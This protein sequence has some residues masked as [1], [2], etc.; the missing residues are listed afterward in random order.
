MN[1]VPRSVCVVQE[2]EYTPTNVG[3]DDIP[4]YDEDWSGVAVRKAAQVHVQDFVMI[5]VAEVTLWGQIRAVMKTQVDQLID[6][7]LVCLLSL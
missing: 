5:N 7:M 1:T 2:C 4:P 3:I 6:V